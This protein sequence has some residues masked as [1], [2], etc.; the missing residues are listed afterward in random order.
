M[1]V[2]LLAI[3][4]NN[5]DQTMIFYSELFELASFDIIPTDYI[6]DWMFDFENNPLTEALDAVGYSSTYTIFNLGS[7]FIFIVI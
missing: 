3:K 1:I 5:P 4:L 7:L 2:H 6:Y